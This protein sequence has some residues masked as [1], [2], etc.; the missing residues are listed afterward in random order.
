MRKCRAMLS[1]VLAIVMLFAVDVPVNAAEI[2]Y[3]SSESDLKSIANAPYGHYVLTEDIELSDSQWTNLGIF[4]GVLDG[5][6][7]A[8]TNLHSAGDGLFDSLGE[9]SV[10]QNLTISGEIS[11]EGE[12]VALLA[13]LSDGTV[14]GCTTQ[15]VITVMDGA[16]GGLLG[17]NRGLVK[18]CVNEAVITNGDSGIVANNLGTVIGC[19]NKGDII[20]D[21]MYPG[22]IAG[23]NNDLIM[24]CVNYGNI[25][26]TLEE[27][28]YNLAVG[29]IVGS[30]NGLVY[31]CENYGEVNQQAQRNGNAGGIVGE[32][33]GYAQLVGC[34]NVGE[35]SGIGRIGGICGSAQL[36]GGIFDENEE[37]II[38]P[39]Q[40]LIAD[41]RNNGIVRTVDKDNHSEYGAGI[42][43]DVSLDGGDASIL[44][45]SNAGAVIGVGN[46]VHCAGCVGGVLLNDDRELILQNLYNS[47]EVTVEFTGDDDTMVSTFAAGIFSGIQNDGN[48]QTQILNCRN[49]GR[50]QANSACGFGTLGANCLMQYCVNTGDVYGTNGAYGFTGDISE[51]TQILDCYSKGT[52]SGK[53]AYGVGYVR[54]ETIEMRNCYYY[55]ELIG[56]ER[57]GV[58]ERYYNGESATVENCYYQQQELLNSESAGVALS[59][60]AMQTQ[61]SYAG[62]DFDNVWE[63]QEQ[64]GAMLPVIKKAPEATAAELQSAN[65]LL[66]PGEVFVPQATSGT[67]VSYYSDNYV[68]LGDNDIFD[69]DGNIRARGLGTVTVYCVFSDGQVLPCTVEISERGNWEI[70]PTPEIIA[71]VERMYNNVLGR[72]AESGGLE[73]WSYTLANYQADGA[74]LAKGFVLSDEFGNKN[75]DNEEFVSILYSTFMDREGDADGIGFWADKL[76][77][78]NSRV[79]VLVGF[80]NSEEFSSICDNYDIARGTMQ[81]DGNVIYNKGVRDFVERMYVKALE[82]DGETVGIEFWTNCLLLDQATPEQVAKEY[83]YSPEYLSKNTSDEDYV[84]SLYQTFMDRE[85]EA[86]GKGYWLTQLQNDVSR[87]TVLEGFA[88]ST[89]FE[90]IMARYGL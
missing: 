14:T 78:G 48:Q 24:D 49:D 79:S 13:G 20:S 76:A 65:V 42:V 5:A 37:L 40:L 12:L 32:M 81:P 38:I 18:D 77:N 75:V 1:L 45:C 47:G 58:I 55:G 62:F 33:T 3:I 57:E 25:T 27:A 22:G 16:A 28:G 89:E 66:R 52:I 31:Q 41:C 86:D 70:E 30:S 15:G 19:T 34:E 71:F 83:F 90:E 63:M 84:E 17:Y 59:V 10:V 68:L 43:A 67:I 85:S 9:G 29:G 88:N 21:A 61:N 74:S 39:G 2:T 72:E 46:D 11:A 64:N 56:T 4:Y 82:R 73:Y 80:V 60:E 44:N 23:V 54:Y 35:V 69:D 50:V 26:S 51:E 53:S 7:Y 6:G 87:E 8:I 36:M